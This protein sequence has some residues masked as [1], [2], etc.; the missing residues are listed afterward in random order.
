[1]ATEQVVVVHPIVDDAVQVDT[2]PATIPVGDDLLAASLRECLAQ[3]TIPLKPRELDAV[4][5]V[6]SRYVSA[7]HGRGWPPESVIMAVKQAAREAGLRA[8][9]N[10][11]LAESR[12]TDTDRLLAELVRWC[13][14]QYYDSPEDVA[15]VRAS[16]KARAEATQHA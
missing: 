10:Q 2:R 13:I 15:I 4:H 7:L 8:S 11:T 3:V 14:A 16:V 5:D 9:A 6:V 12:W 1:M